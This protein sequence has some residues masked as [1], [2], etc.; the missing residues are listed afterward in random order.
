MTDLNS[1][2]LPF[3]KSSIVTVVADQALK[4]SF[5]AKFARLIE[6][7]ISSAVFSQFPQGS[8][9]ENLRRSVSIAADTSLSK[10]SGASPIHTHLY[11]DQ[12]FI[13]AR[14]RTARA[15][16]REVLQGANDE[17]AWRNI[18]ARGGRGLIRL[19][20]GQVST[21]VLGMAQGAVALGAFGTQAIADVSDVFSYRSRSDAQQAAHEKSGAFRNF[22]RI[23]EMGKGLAYLG[24]T[25]AVGSPAE[26]QALI[27]SVKSQM[28]PYLTKAEFSA[29]LG[30]AAFSL[31]TSGG[32]GAGAVKLHNMRKTEKA[33]KIAEAAGEGISHLNDV[34]RLPLGQRALD[35]VKTEMRE[36]PR[37]WF[38]GV[39]NAAGKVTN[40]VAD[41]TRGMIDTVSGDRRLFELASVGD[42]EGAISSAKNLSVRE[43]LIKLVRDGL[44]MADKNKDASSSIGNR[45]ERLWRQIEAELD[46]TGENA[47]ALAREKAIREE[48]RV[49]RRTDTRAVGS[50]DGAQEPEGKGVWDELRKEL[51]ALYAKEEIKAAEES[52]T[53]APT[54]AGS[55]T[56][57]RLDTQGRLQRSDAEGT[58]VPIEDVSPTND[59][60]RALIAGK[61]AASTADPE[62][63]AA[64]LKAQGAALTLEKS[65]PRAAQFQKWRLQI[66]DAAAMLL[67]RS[68][69]NLTR[70]AWSRLE[71]AQYRIARLIEAARDGHKGGFSAAEA[72][73]HIPY[74]T[75]LSSD[76][77][78]RISNAAVMNLNRKLDILEGVIENPMR[79][80]YSGFEFGSRDFAMLHLLDCYKRLE[81]SIRSLSL[82][83]P[84]KI[85]DDVNPV[86]DMLG[87]LYVR[88]ARGVIS[89]GWLRKKRSVLSARINTQL[90]NHFYKPAIDGFMKLRD[91]RGSYFEKDLEALDGAFNDLNEAGSWAEYSHVVFT[92]L[93]DP[94]TAASR[95]GTNI[96]FNSR[97]IQ[98]VRR[99][100]TQLPMLRS[101]WL[102]DSTHA[103]Q[104]LDEI[105]TDLI[106][107]VPQKRLEPKIWRRGQSLIRR[108]H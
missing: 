57:W 24:K 13:A 70:L 28:D 97:L 100:D 18:A 106:K 17:E 62:R 44:R 68:D 42:V 80:P 89:A 11:L 102:T 48:R 99:A 75:E 74:L 30:L 20:A 14:F 98:A 59:V 9:S 19:G 23:I 38:A 88:Y 54:Q 8:N 87:K 71:E 86:R 78:R 53:A 65:L 4:N 79:S 41:G 52:V 107:V 46:P 83:L 84:I 77:Y 101:I 45:S 92:K 63:V 27:Q 64:L 6:I 31:L 10:N 94:V 37:V 103:R 91:L 40:F 58:W 108:G 51:N 35:F 72:P 93:E 55:S 96:E 3:A 47:T 7:P 73:S 49:A 82:L 90:Q 85:V 56:I 36:M 43:R 104:I 76:L 66:T 1:K 5:A 95:A 32:S 21:F 15:R 105:I 22:R 34:P 12:G 39:R 25:I 61:I 16:V 67:Q 29:G 69:A 26:R 81:H 60:P 50:V 33:A 2:S